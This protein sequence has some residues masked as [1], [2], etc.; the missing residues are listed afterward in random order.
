M[1]VAGLCQ[2]CDLLKHG[3]RGERTVRDIH[4]A[5]H[6]V[7]ITGLRMFIHKHQTLPERMT[8]ICARQT[9]PHALKGTIY[10]QGKNIGQEKADGFNSR[11][12]MTQPLVK[13]TRNVHAGKSLQLYTLTYLRG[14]IDK[15]ATQQTQHIA[16]RHAIDREKT[17]A[18]ECTCS[19]VCVSVCVC[20][21]VCV[22]LCA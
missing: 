19:H 3:V 18:W 5:L 2:R 8:R 6:A 13:L 10:A 14:E 15:H 7:P 16:A 12:R 1:L 21:C 22:S 9:K 4:K 20:V 17:H 11:P